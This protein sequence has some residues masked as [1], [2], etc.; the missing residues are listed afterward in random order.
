MTP[1]K[2][3]KKIISVFGCVICELQRGSVMDLFLI[4]GPAGCPLLGAKTV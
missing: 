2:K 3:I 1:P 4:V